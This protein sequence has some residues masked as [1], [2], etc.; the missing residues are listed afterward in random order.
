MTPGTRRRKDSSSPSTA[1]SGPS[2]PRRRPPSACPGELRRSILSYFINN[3]VTPTVTEH[4][5]NNFTDANT[6]DTG[7]FPAKQVSGDRLEFGYTGEHHGFLVDTFE[8]NCQTQI[9][10][11]EDVHVVFKIRT[12]N[13]VPA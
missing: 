2:R 7:D 1:S 5:I 9:I 11:G 4:V 6:F 3:N 8:L 10:Y 13:P 12:A